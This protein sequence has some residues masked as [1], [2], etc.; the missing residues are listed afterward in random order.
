MA[1][2]IQELIDGEKNSG[3][4]AAG[5]GLAQENALRKRQRNEEPSSPSENNTTL[6][7]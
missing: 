5:I 2:S 7:P 4:P 1:K 6:T 3:E